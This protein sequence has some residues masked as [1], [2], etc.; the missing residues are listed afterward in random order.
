MILSQP[1]ENLPLQKMDYHAKLTS[2]RKRGESSQLVQDLIHGTPSPQVGVLK[3]WL[4]S[5]C[6]HVYQSQKFGANLSTI[7]EL[8]WKQTN[9]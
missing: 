7:L 6:S 8:S 3:I 4:F 2:C 1:A 5:N 9:Q